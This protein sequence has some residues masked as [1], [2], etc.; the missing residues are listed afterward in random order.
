MTTKEKYTVV[1][2]VIKELMNANLCRDN[3][4]ETQDQILIPITDTT[5]IGFDNNE[6]IVLCTTGRDIPADIFKAIQS[7]E[8]LHHDII[9]HI[10]YLLR[11]K[12]DTTFV[13]KMYNDLIK[14]EAE[15]ETKISDNSKRIKNNND[16]V[17]RDMMTVGSTALCGI[18][19]RAIKE[20]NLS[21]TKGCGGL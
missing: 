15:Y 21:D 20:E 3:V 2:Y 17:L 16:A 6:Y 8:E 5:Y 14:A 4:Y 9:P 13:R 7:Q 1:I 18:G 12:H 19:S 11:T 10:H